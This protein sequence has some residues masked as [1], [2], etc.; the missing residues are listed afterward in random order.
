VLADLLVGYVSTP[1]LPQ[2]PCVTVTGGSGL[3]FNLGELSAAVSALEPGE[4]IAYSIRLD[5][6]LPAR[7]ATI[8]ALSYRLRQIDR[9]LDRGKVTIVGTFGI[10]P[11]LDAPSFVYELNS[12]A[13][14]YADRCLRPRGAGE[15]LRRVVTYFCGY[16]LALGGIVVIGRKA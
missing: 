16:D 13:A 3:R 6:P 9:V 5:L 8:A 1:G 12:A 2:S 7:L 10:D 11:H 15:Q 4:Y 14:D